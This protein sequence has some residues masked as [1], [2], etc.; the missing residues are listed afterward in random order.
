MRKIFPL[1]LLLAFWRPVLPGAARELDTGFH[2]LYNLRFQQAREQF[3]Q[4]QHLHPD[5]PMGPTAE[6]AAYLFEE[7][8][9]HNVL[10]SE[11]FLDDDRLLGGIKGKADETRKKA[12]N[13]ANARAA[14]LAGRRLASHPRDVTALLVM[15]ITTG[16]QSDYASLIEKRQLESLRLARKASDYGSRLLAVAPHMGDGYM[17]LGTA[18]Y[19]IAC[20]PAYKRLFLRIG[21]IRGYKRAGMH[22]LALAA[23]HGHYLKPFAKM[24]LFLASLRE[25]QPGAARRWLAELEA[26]LPESPVVRRER[27][28]LDLALAA[29][30]AE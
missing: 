24:M 17:A 8:E 1:L 30:G 9:R 13:S 18:N 29:N 7:F 6:A 26:D 19:I 16:M 12:F 27:A 23:E 25:K 15:T 11:F 14:E 5:D 28:R 10:T 4:W 2:L 21:G 3:K 20:L 22:Q